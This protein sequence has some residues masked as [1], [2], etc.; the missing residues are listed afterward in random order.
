MK[1][2]F[3][4]LTFFSIITLFAQTDDLQNDRKN[5]LHVN[6]FYPIVFKSLE[7]DYERIINEDSSY[8]VSVLYANYENLKKHYMLSPYYRKYFSKGN[9]KGFYMDTFLSLNGGVSENYNYDYIFDDQ[10]QTGYYVE[11]KDKNKF[12]D[13]AF[14][15]SAGVKFLSSDHFVGILH[16]SVA[17]NLFAKDGTNYDIIGKGGIS[18]GYRF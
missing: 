11:Y 9:A 10:S 13:V 6:V 17:R 8:G 3:F 14:G 4:T 2:L 12:T 16:M 15:L 1:K 18:V 7:V 5:E